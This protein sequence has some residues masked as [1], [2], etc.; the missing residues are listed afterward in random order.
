MSLQRAAPGVGCGIRAFSATEAR[1]PAPSSFF[2]VVRSD[3]GRKAAKEERGP[4]LRLFVHVPFFRTGPSEL[5][6]ALFVGAEG[7]GVALV[8]DPAVVEH[9][10]PVGD[11]DRG[12][13]D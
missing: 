3:S 6:H 4:R 9:I 7:A 8:D 2:G 11:F 12:A 13:Q 10:G 1:G 5:A